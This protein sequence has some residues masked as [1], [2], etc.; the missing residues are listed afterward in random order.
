MFKTS[1][2]YIPALFRDPITTNNS[3]LV[4]CPGHQQ[5]PGTPLPYS[6]KWVMDKWMNGW[7]T[8]KVFWRYAVTSFLS[9][10]DAARLP[11]LSLSVRIMLMWDAEASGSC[12]EVKPRQQKITWFFSVFGL[13]RTV[14]QG[15]HVHRQYPSKNPSACISKYPWAGCWTPNSPWCS[16]GAFN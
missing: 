16:V 4:T 10:E 13:V 2:P 7:I 12:G 5:T 9:L 14:A 6:R 3:H 15:T 1:T 11:S 8:A